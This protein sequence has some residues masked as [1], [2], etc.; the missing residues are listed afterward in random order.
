MYMYCLYFKLCNYKITRLLHR[1]AR[2]RAIFFNTVML[3]RWIYVGVLKATR[4]RNIS[5]H[6]NIISIVLTSVVY[7][8]LNYMYMY[9]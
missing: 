8:Y 4:I 1:D 9:V 2:V 5:H 3:Y 7:R 6:I